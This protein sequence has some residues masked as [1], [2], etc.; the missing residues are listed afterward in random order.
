MP[1]E[2]IFHRLEVEANGFST[3]NIRGANAN[4]DLKKMLEETLSY[5]RAIYEDTQKMLKYQQLRLIVN[6]VWIVLVVAPMLVALF[7]LPPLLKNVMGS[8][9]GLLGPDNAQPSSIINDLKQ[10]K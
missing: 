2:D 5:S 10:F 3:P 8:Y 1:K 7:W 9:Q 4:D 6:V